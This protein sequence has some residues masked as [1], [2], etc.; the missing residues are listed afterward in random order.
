MGAPARR[1]RHRARRRR[2]SASPRISSIPTYRDFERDSVAYRAAL[3]DSRPF[4]RWAERN[5][6]RH[7]RKGYAI[8]TLSLK[9]TGTPP[10]DATADEMD[11]IAELAERYSFGEV[12]VTHEQNLV[13]AD[14]LQNDLHGL[15]V[16]LQ[17]LGL[18]DAEHRPPHRHRLLPGRRLLLARQCQVDPDRR[19][20]PAALRR[21]RLPVRP[22]RPRAQHV[23]LHE[24]LRPPSRR[25]HRHPRRRQ[26]RRGVVPDLDRRRAGQRRRRSAR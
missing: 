3:A 23:G 10:G 21:S 2:S 15:W 16:R 22:R 20:D 7:K 13:L 24:R 9:R 17:A 14:V 12:R 8:V 18:R 1:S 11:A 4:S 25:Q 6:Q 5:V 26:E 19:G